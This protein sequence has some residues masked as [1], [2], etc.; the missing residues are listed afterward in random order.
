MA[1]KRLDV[2]EKLPN[3]K[4][5]EK[6]TVRRYNENLPEDLL[7]FDINNYDYK[8][9]TDKNQAF[10]NSLIAELEEFVAINAS[11]MEVFVRDIC[12]TIFIQPENAR[13]HFDYE[14]FK[15]EYSYWRKSTDDWISTIRKYPTE[16]GKEFFFL[17]DLRSQGYQSTRWD[18]GM[19]NRSNKDYFFILYDLYLKCGGKRQYIDYIENKSDDTECI[20]ELFK[21]AKIKT[22]AGITRKGVWL[23]NTDPFFEAMDYLNAISRQDIFIVIDNT[24]DTS[25]VLFGKQ[26][27]YEFLCLEKKV[28]KKNFMYYWTS[29]AYAS[30]M[31][32]MKGKRFIVNNTYV[33]QFDLGVYKYLGYSDEGKLLFGSGGYAHMF[34][35]DDMFDDIE[36][37]VH[38]LELNLKE[39]RNRITSIKTELENDFGEKLNQLDEKVENYK[40]MIGRRIDSVYTVANE[41]PEVKSRR[42]L[43][44]RVAEINESYRLGTH[45]CDDTIKWTDV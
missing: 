35:A 24:D 43:E 1:L 13:G 37:R 45:N 36:Y 26:D 2:T 33:R 25:V 12:E 7:L 14:D 5:L 38:N 16:K 42:M 29:M 9:V 44:M 41:E 34:S 32:N 27:L 31:V 6:F 20:Y 22:G 4:E 10:S 18:Y 39:M 28:T 21:D 15:C 30:S 19:K 3:Y 40:E 8:L 11:K 17:F 23:N